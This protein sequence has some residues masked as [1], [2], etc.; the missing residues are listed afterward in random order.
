MQ[1]EFALSMYDQ[2]KETRDSFDRSRD[3]NNSR[4]MQSHNSFHPEGYSRFDLSN[5][6]TLRPA[7][8]TNAI[9]S[10]TVHHRS[11]TEFALAKRNNAFRCYR[12]QRIV[13]RNYEKSRQRRRN[14]ARQIGSSSRY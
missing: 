13:A 1:I 4:S 3:K 7:A 6:R 5:T 12:D 2:K 11:S 8:A 9:A 10:P 14:A